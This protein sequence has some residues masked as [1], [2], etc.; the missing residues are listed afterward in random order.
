MILPFQL[1]LGEGGRGGRREE[2]SDIRVKCFYY[3]VMVFCYS[4]G[5][6]HP[7]IVDVDWRLDCCIKVR[8][9]RLNSM[10]I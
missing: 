7:H 5:R 1:M 3:L 10:Q 9:F 4:V 6:C 8:C 2:E